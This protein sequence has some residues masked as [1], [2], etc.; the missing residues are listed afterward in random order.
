LIITPGSVRAD[1]VA[2]TGARVTT[3]PFGSVAAFAF[4]PPVMLITI[5]WTR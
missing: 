2:P 3:N 4:A 5:D 1:E